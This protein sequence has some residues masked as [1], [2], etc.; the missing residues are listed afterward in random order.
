MLAVVQKYSAAM[1]VFLTLNAGAV[2]VE[3]KAGTTVLS[4]IPQRVAALNWTQAEILL[5]LGITPAGVTTVKGYRQWQSDTPPMPEGVTELG[6][7]SEPSLEA[8]AALKPDLILGYDWRHNRIYP[9][10]NAIAP[11][12][13]YGQYP[14]EEDQR[15]YLVRM[16][17]IFQSVAAIFQHEQQAAVKLSEMQQ[18]LSQGRMLIRK[19]GLTG[20]PVVVGKFVGMGLGL[21]VYGKSSLAGAVVEEIGLENGW[22]ATLPGR[23]FTHVDLLKLTTIGDASLII[24]GQLPD[25]GQGMTVSPVWQALPAVREGRV[26]H[27]PALWSF[28]G[29]ESVMRMTRAFVDQLVPEA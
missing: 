17:D 15:D 16:L 6:H 7:R 3:H 5:T 2:T 11:T 27:V 19:A 24:I 13:L 8:I 14:S 12:V 29:P 20:H 23:D 10:L 9:E 26:Y 28:G 22:S 18:V 25:N 4:E 21:R 1:V